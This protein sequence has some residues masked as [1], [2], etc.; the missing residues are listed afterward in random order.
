M[1]NYCHEKLTVSV[2]L[3]DQVVLMVQSGEDGEGWRG[4]LEGEE[5]LW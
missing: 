5:D 4:H 1:L 2:A 3:I